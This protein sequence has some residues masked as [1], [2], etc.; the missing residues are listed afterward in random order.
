[1]QAALLTKVLTDAKAGWS[2]IQAFILQNEPILETEDS[3]TQASRSRRGNAVNR[4]AMS[5][6][7]NSEMLTYIVK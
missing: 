3:T 1:M 5:P 6:Y 2:A 4:V 7:I